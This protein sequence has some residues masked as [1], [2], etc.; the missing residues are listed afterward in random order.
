MQLFLQEI[1]PKKNKSTKLMHPFTT[2]HSQNDWKDNQ[3]DILV[4]YAGKK[5]WGEI[6]ELVNRNTKSHHSPLQCHKK[7]KEI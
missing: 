2:N 3:I 1:L 7:F 4:E 6:S 5:S